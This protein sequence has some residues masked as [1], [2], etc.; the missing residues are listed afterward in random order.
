ML[1]QISQ[2]SDLTITKDIFNIVLFIFNIIFFVVVGTVTL[3][4]YKSA[5]R[6]LLNTV[7][8]EYQKRVMDKLSSLSEELYSEYDNSSEN[9]WAKNN[10]TLEIADQLIEMYKSEIGILGH[11]ISLKV[12][13]LGTLLDKLKSDP[14]I[15][16][17][18]SIVLVKHLEKRVNTMEEIYFS[19]TEEFTENLKK[20]KFDN[21]LDQAKYAFH[22]QIIDKLY[23]N[24]CGISQI[25]EEIH[26]IRIEIKKYLQSFNPFSK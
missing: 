8:T 3:L 11:P 20:G 24:K 1:Q 26:H 17:E 18:I 6:G 16:D 25:E 2:P 23:E 13:K 5:R 22:N 19:E 7:N 14:F 15:P 4:T 21:N 12:R 9:Y 10:D